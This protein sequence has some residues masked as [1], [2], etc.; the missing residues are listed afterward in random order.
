MSRNPREDHT[1]Y[2]QCKHYPAHNVCQSLHQGQTLK[3]A[4]AVALQKDSA[5]ALHL[6]C[7]HHAIQRAH[8]EAAYGSRPQEQG[9][10]GGTW[11]L[12]ARD[13]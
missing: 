5:E 4:H 10:D 8:R 7:R 2:L 9:Y 11:T 12:F 1:E 6:L 3:P 13:G